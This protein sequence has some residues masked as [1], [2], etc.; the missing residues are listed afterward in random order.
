MLQK[1]ARLKR[2]LTSR[3]SLDNSY[4]NELV[5]SIHR[6]NVTS[7][8]FSIVWAAGPVTVI[9]ISLGYYL[10]HGTRV[11][12]ETVIYFSFYA[13]FVG[14]VGFLSKLVFD[15]IQNSKQED[16]QE[17]FLAIIDESYS[18]LY[19][20]KK[21]NLNNLTDDVKN[22]KIA[23]ELLSKSHP[24]SKEIFYAFSIH[25]NKE[26]AEFA[27]IIHLHIA[28]GFPIDSS[29]NRRKLTKFYKMIDINK[30]IPLALKSKFF[31]ALNGKYA[32]LKKGVERKVGFLSKVYNSAGQHGLFDLDDVNQVIAFFIELLSGRRIYYYKALSKFEDNKKDYL[33]GLIEKLRSTIN[34]KYNH[35]QGVHKQAFLTV[36]EVIPNLD[37]I[38]IINVSEDVS[39]N[40]DLL[41]RSLRDI[42]VKK[43]D[44]VT[45][46]QFMLTKSRFAQN[47]HIITSLL[48]RLDLLLNQWHA[49]SFDKSEQINNR[50]IEYELSYVQLEEKSR[51]VIAYKM[52]AYLNYDNSFDCKTEEIKEFAYRAVKLIQQPISLDQPSILTAIELSSGANL[53]SIQINTSPK[54]KLDT[55]YNLCR[56]VKTDIKEIRQRVKKVVIAQYS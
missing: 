13:F 16:M 10:S 38:E 55:T 19:L 37:I 31:Q 18:Y 2:K 48:N 27:E 12:L 8:F 29:Q 30:D 46:K 40:I 32:S 53:S 26:L 41:D 25:F 39:Y 56:S 4:L 11:P 44:K 45:K 34:Q 43:L 35:I 33:F 36:S 24:T 54:Q 20:S 7:T 42:R 14:L 23:Y 22:N 9:A 50:N 47:L 15:A 28:N 6:A 5:S 51:M 1:L 49:L 17:K 3:N 21:L 52:S